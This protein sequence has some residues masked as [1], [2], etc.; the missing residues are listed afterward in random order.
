[1]VINIIYSTCLIRSFNF[2]LSEVFAFLHFLF[3]FSLLCAQRGE[4]ITVVRFSNFNYR[5]WVSEIV[6]FAYLFSVRV[7]YPGFFESGT[8]WARL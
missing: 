6:C 2:Y 7:L 4:I 5:I 8:L 1:M 3:V